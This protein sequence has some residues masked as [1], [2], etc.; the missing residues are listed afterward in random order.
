MG[1]NDN[2]LIMTTILFEEREVILRKTLG[3][4]P[5]VKKLCTE[6]SVLQIIDTGIDIRLSLMIDNTP[7]ARM[8]CKRENYKPLSEWTEVEINNKIMEVL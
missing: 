3:N 2:L 1:K 8:L 4:I 7:F 5:E 6:L